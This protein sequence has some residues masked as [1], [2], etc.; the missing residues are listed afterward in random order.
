[1]G[2]LTFLGESGSRLHRLSPSIMC[3]AG[4]PDLAV[5]VEST[6]LGAGSGAEVLPSDRVSH[7]AKTRSATDGCLSRK[8]ASAQVIDQDER[9]DWCRCEARLELGPTST[10]WIWS[11]SKRRKSSVR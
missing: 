10:P 2:R 3:A 5:C 9:P 4:T 1:M 8:L 7:T 11:P 6:L